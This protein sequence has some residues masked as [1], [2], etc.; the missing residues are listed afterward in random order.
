M[1]YYFVPSSGIFGGVKVACQMV[2]MLNR[3]GVRAVIVTPDG[4]A[5][6]WFSIRAPIVH[7]AGA[8]EE[9]N[10][11]DWLMITWPPDYHRFRNQ[12]ARL[13]CHC[14]GTDDR[15]DPIFADFEVE[16]LTCWDQ[17]TRYVRE[18]FARETTQVG[19]AIS[20]CFYFDGDRKEDNQVTYMPRRGLRTALRCIFRNPE[21]DFRPLDNLDEEEVASCLK[22]AGIF[23]ATALGEQFGLPAL[24]AMA[25]GCVVLSVPVKGGTEYLQNGY[26]CLV[27]Q[28][29]E[30]AERLRWITRDENAEL[31]ARMRLRAV[32]TAQNYRYER[33]LKRMR[34]L[35]EGELNW[36]AL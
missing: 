27:V 34:R 18:K 23:L 4:Q 15:M 19:I 25:A 21:L 11:S 31:R 16:V 1:I 36:L 22:H 10:S 14:Q 8:L 35:I 7:E 26:N 32:A 3:L 33:H 28:P 13:V 30:M 2:E 5:P 24:E 17:A 6:H 12:T 9:L 29:A 20:D